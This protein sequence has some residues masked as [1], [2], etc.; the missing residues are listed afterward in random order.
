MSLCVGIYKQMLYMTC[1]TCGFCL[2]SRE[3]KY[4]EMWLRILNDT[5]LDDEGKQVARNK[6]LNELGVKRYCCRM[7][8]MSSI[9]E[10]EK[11][12]QRQT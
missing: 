5:S 3:L 9:H 10:E 1:P 12:A 8:L 2:G 6:L 7:R 11:L 4:E